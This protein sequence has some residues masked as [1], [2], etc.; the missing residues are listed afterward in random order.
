[1]YFKE[2]ILI[3]LLFHQQ[4]NFLWIFI[5]IPQIHISDLHQWKFTN[6]NYLENKALGR[7]WK[8]GHKKWET[9]KIGNT[10]LFLVVDA[11]SGNALSFSG[12]KL[13]IGI[14]VNL[15]VEDQS[16]PKQKWDLA[17][18]KRTDWIKLKKPNGFFLE[19]SECGNDL[20][21]QGTY[22]VSTHQHLFNFGNCFDKIWEIDID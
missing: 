7:N 19:S 4:T 8:Y 3:S 5:W 9:K 12:E 13:E 16:D 21:I 6:D 20:I 18:D 17:K 2:S 22:S 1:M 15:T 10:A 14:E 11:E